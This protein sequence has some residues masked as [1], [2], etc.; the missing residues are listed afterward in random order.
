MKK[1]SFSNIS[2]NQLRQVVPLRQIV[3]DTRFDTWFS[4]QPPLDKEEDAL[5]SYVLKKHRP[6][7]TIRANASK[8]IR[9]K[10]D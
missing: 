10:N 5:L 9:F 8:L 6:Y 1:L 2:L 7:F 3:D 4:Y